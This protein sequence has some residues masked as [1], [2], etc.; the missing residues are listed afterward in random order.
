[1]SVFNLKSRLELTVKGS[2]SYHLSRSFKQKSQRAWQF[3]QKKTCSFPG[4]VEAQPFCPVQAPMRRPQWTATASIAEE[5][6]TIKK[7]WLNHQEWCEKAM[8]IGVETSQHVD[9]RWIKLWNMG[10]LRWKMGSWQWTNKGFAGSALWYS[11]LAKAT[12]HLYHIGIQ[13]CDFPI[14]NGSF[15]IARL[16][17][18]DICTTLVVSTCCILV[19]KGGSN[20]CYVWV[21]D[22]QILVSFQSNPIGFSNQ[23]PA[24][25]CCTQKLPCTS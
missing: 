22:P 4:R 6:L 2:L 8:K 25:S 1:M 12:L 21:W 14:K 9:L 23:R 7:W 19:A 18:S 3:P 24:A 15:A 20:V 17:G 13:L 10:C 16:P 11:N 5:L